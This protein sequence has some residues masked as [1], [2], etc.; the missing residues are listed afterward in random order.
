MKELVGIFWMV[1]GV[2]GIIMCWIVWMAWDEANCAGLCQ[3]R[4]HR[5]HINGD[6][7]CLEGHWEKQ[8]DD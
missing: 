4:E 1:M 8:R 3:Q 7:Y 6:C 5:Y 2:V